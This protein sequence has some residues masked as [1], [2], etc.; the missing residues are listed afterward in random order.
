MTTDKKIGIAIIGTGFGKK[1]HIPAFQDHPKTQVVAVYH[2]DLDI[3]QNLI[4]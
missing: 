4:L 1:V 3:L 2:R